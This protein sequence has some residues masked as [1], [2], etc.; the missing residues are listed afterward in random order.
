[1]KKTIMLAFPFILSACSSPPEPA[2]V[3]WGAKED[4]VNSTLPSWEESGTVNASTNVTGKWMKTV[5]GFKTD[6]PLD[7]GVYYAISHSTNIV[8]S[9]SSSKDWFDT[10]SWLRSHGANGV[11]DFE[12]KGA[13]LTC[14][15]IDV[16]FYRGIPRINHPPVTPV[17]KADVPKPQVSP[18]LPPV[19]VVAN[20]KPAAAVPEKYA[21]GS[22]KPAAVGK[23]LTGNPAPAITAKTEPAKVVTTDKPKS[24]FLVDT[25]PKV[26]ASPVKR[27]PAPVVVWRGDVGSTLKETVF[28][29]AGTQSCPT[30][31]NWRVMWE[32]PVN[33]SIDAPLVFNGDFKNALNGI[34]GLYLHAEKP[35]YPITN[36]G[37]CWLKV[38][39]KG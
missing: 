35:L 26:V 17:K 21:L 24:P 34:F 1:M 29:W 12:F 28:R 3:D 6:Q 18:L 32:T 33:Y 36:S 5:R 23:P 30:G 10:K 14:T 9:A 20:K 16:S 22:N 27:E 13:C 8:V 2:S 37:Q 7:V 25:R 31:G 19:A 39:D 4:T 15:S 38:T 11:I